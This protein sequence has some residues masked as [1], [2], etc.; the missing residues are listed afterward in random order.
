MSLSNRFAFRIFSTEIII[1]G[2]D[3]GNFPSRKTFCWK[4]FR[5]Y[6]FLPK[7]ILAEQFSGISGF[8]R[9]IFQNFLILVESFSEFPASGENLNPNFVMHCLAKFSIYE[10]LTVEK[11]NNSYV[12][13]S[14]IKL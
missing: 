4:K 6:R 11:F 8:R 12:K 7:K 13:C 9:K 10:M 1:T 5:L 14:M 3:V 2:K